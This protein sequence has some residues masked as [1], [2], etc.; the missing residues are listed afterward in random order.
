MLSSEV[1]L[2]LEDYLTTIYRLEEVFGIAKTTLLASELNVR[3]ATVAKII[4]KLERRGLVERSKYRGVRLTSKGRR[5]AA[6]IVRRHR[7]LESYLERELKFNSF[8]VHELAH[9]L[10]H[11]PREFIERIYDKAGK[12][13][14][15]PHGNPVLTSE[16]IM[17]KDK[18]LFEVEENTWHLVVR[19]AGELRGVLSKL[20]EH[21][22]NVGRIV[23]VL[24]KT[25]KGLKVEI[26]DLGVVELD[27]ITSKTI[28][29]RKAES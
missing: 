11:M 17:G 27:L 1:S 10:E 21:D 19:I 20:K 6:P 26:K 15:C 28:K 18:S 8:E 3:P 7:I 9:K 14:F 5:I 16:P 29:V 2:T 4:K 24:G 23:R 22:L 12:P 25:D 13:R